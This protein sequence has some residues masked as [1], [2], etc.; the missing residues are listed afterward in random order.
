MKPMKRIRKP[1]NKLVT[2]LK[3]LRDSRK[4]IDNCNFNFVCNFYEH[5]KFMHLQISSGID[6]SMLTVAYRQYF[7]FLVSCWE[8]Y[9]RD[10]FVLINSSDAKLLSQTLK[11]LNIDKYDVTI[12]S[13]EISLPELASKSFNFQ[14]L[15]DINSAFTSLIDADFLNYVCK[16]KIT[17]CAIKGR[18]ARDLSIES[19][20]TDWRDIITNAF[21]IR[22]NIVH[23]ANY[24]IEY[25]PELIQKIET[26]FLLIPQATTYF[27]AKKF[28]LKNF[29]MIVDGKN[30]GPNL[31]I[32]D[33]IL[34]E[35]WELVHKESD[36]KAHIAIR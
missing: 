28:N 19:L 25:Q 3:Q 22:H 5:C 23:D 7:V 35:D 36:N 32:V 16:N 30:I 20:I 26:L 34:S 31:F 27:I 12:E 29:C 24:R 18:Q 8:T 15:E 21:N 10:T 13:A 11:H 4:S 2:E 9:F 1:T 14:N 6:K 17:S 33:D